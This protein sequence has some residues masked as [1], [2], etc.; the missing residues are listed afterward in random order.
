MPA[1]RLG[2][3]DAR[4]LAVANG[5]ARS[6]LG[7]VALVAPGLPLRPWLGDEGRQ[8][9]ARM[10]ARALGGRDL[11]IGVGTLLAAG[12]HQPLRAWVEAAG[13][14]DAGDVAVTLG[15]FGARPGSGRLAVLAAASGGVAAAVLAARELE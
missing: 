6:A 12:R 11:A 7:V 4:R 2:P 3:V 8:P 14:A 13:V 9:A 5:L 1:M 10:L 15:R